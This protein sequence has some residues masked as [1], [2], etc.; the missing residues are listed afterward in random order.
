[1]ATTSP[2]SESKLR[3]GDTD[4]VVEGLVESRLKKKYGRG[5]FVNDVRKSKDGTLFITLGNTVPKNVSDC[6]E[7]DRVL[8]F[9]EFRNIHTL[10][11]ESLEKGYLIDLPERG[12]IYEGFRARRRDLARR[13]DRNMAQTIY[14]QLI[15]FTPVENQLGAIK[16]ILRTVREHAPLPVETIYE[17]RGQN[18][19][20]QTERYLRL[21][22]DTDFVQID[23]DTIRS[24]ANLDV[25]DELDV[26]TREFSEIVLGQV[27]NQ[28]FSTLRDELNLTLL[29]HYPKYA[30]SYYFSALQRGEPNLRLDVES[31]HENLEMLHEESV[32]EI[33]VQ[34]KLDDLAEVDVLQTEGE[35]YKSN[36]EIYGNL[37]AQSV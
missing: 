28:A 12:E 20:E 19:E 10:K 35:F 1:M 31:A 17:I 15:E 24:A 36:P 37:A 4:Q 27:V 25:H 32:H 22:E 34:Q 30:N 6:R 8:K 3:F 26:G 5:I 13:L 33:T 14:S 7:H 11:A 9:I 21:L 18:N 23:S 2:G 16:E 29:A